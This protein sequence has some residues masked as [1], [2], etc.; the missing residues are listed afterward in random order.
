MDIRAFALGL[1][2]KSPSF[3]NPQSQSYIQ[4][5]S[6]NDASRGQAV[7]ENLCATYGVSKEQAIEQAR[8][9]FGIPS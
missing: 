5:I 3:N 1:L 8:R 4:A 9:F 7:A 2:S 6:S